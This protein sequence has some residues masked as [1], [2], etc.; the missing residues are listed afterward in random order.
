MTTRY[1]LK[2]PIWFLTLTCIYGAILTA[3]T[4]LNRVG[5]DRWWAGA[6]NLYL[7]QI[8]WAAP[9]VLLTVLSLKAARRWVWAPLL[10][11]AWVLGP[12]MD[13]CWGTQAPPGSADVRIMSWN[14]KYGGFN[15]VT[16]LAITCD[17]E[18]FGPD[19]VLLQDAG[20]LLNGPI[21]R[22]FRGWNVRSFD[23]YV[24]A[25]K[26]PLDEAQVQ[27]LPFRGENYTCLRCRLHIGAKT[28]VLYDVHFQSPRQGLDAFREVRREP[29]YLPRA[30]QEL[31]DNVEA[32][33]SQAR[34]L[35]RLIQQEQEPVVVAGDLNSPD[36]SLACATLRQAGLHDAFAEGGRGY[37]YTYGYFVLRRRLS[38][39]S[40][41]WMRIDH[42]MLSSQL[43]SHACK[44][45]TEN[46]SEHRPVVADVVLTRG[47]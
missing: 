20:G 30:I 16:Q 46:V 26:L 7:P 29:W 23:Q 15:K 40:A 1:R 42:I 45:G 33:L 21:G 19:V 39:L 8:V 5:S 14:V 18:Q 34:A 11:V 47:T 44:A 4:V 2:V 31:G 36:A 35:G 3:V 27:L 25:S 43:Q 28:L 24:I 37:G 12:I 38:W 32:R 22:F 13:L 41:S 10:C 9:G 6:L 17:I